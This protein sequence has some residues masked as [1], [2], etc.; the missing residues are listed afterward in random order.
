MKYEVLGG[1][2]PV[3]GVTPELFNL[4]RLHEVPQLVADYLGCKKGSQG[5]EE[6]FRAEISEL[7]NAELYRALTFKTDLSRISMILEEAGI[8]YIPLKG[9]II[10][11]I[12]P[13]NWM[14]SSTDID[15]LVRPHDIDRATD[16]ITQ[17]AGYMLVNQ[18][19]HHTL[20]ESKT[21]WI[22]EM[23]FDLSPGEHDARKLLDKAW[24]YAVPATGHRYN[25]TAEFFEMYFY[26]HL[27]HHARK[28]G[29]LGL[30]QMMDIFMIDCKNKSTSTTSGKNL[31]ADILA[32]SGKLLGKAGL[33]RF[34]TAART[35]AA[36]WFGDLSRKKA[37]KSLGIS[38]EEFEEMETFALNGGMGGT[39]ES[40]MTMR[41]ADEAGKGDTN[42]AAS[43]IVLSTEDLASMHKEVREN[44]KL[45][46]IYQVKRWA[47]ILKPGRAAKA[48]KE[49]ELA[50]SIGDNE[51]DRARRVLRNLGL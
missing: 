46:P 36:V 26:Y 47:R 25:F 40:K 29:A 12:Y 42:Y 10:R 21:G 51:I 5:A 1:D 2:K 19:G 20:I 3:I 38:L 41:R 7:Y 31:E 23:H 45:A 11:D 34:A 39:K 6:K 14:R 35:I 30:R 27:S 9:A 32:S 48:K 43:R 13:K 8:D 18:S 28:Q 17:Q 44:P 22:I 24:D 33:D 49:I 15:I 37:V 50:S 4:A 16:V